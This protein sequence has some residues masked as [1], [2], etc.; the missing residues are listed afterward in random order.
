MKIL[1]EISFLGTAYRGYQVQPNVPTVQGYLNAATKDLFGFDCDIVG[2]SR[3]DSG[4]HSNQFFLTV[5]K[6]GEAGIRT[7]IPIK[8]IPLALSVRLPNDISVISARYVDDSFHARYS[9]KYKEYLYVIWNSSVR[10]PF[11]YDRSWQYEK[12][13]D[14]NALSKMNLAAQRFVGTHDFSAYMASNTDVENTVRTIFAAEIYREGEKIF[15]KV[16]A[17]GFLYNMVRILTGTLIAVAEGKI[18]PEDIDAITNS[19]NR[20]N[21]GMTVP[22]QGLF[23]NKVVY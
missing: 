1:L 5:S 13:I 22:A 7:R 11:G 6:K 3:T 14:D 10:D 19:K 9:V 21:A 12:Y 15:F 23:L 20:K 8:K 4:V 17:D 2:C 16:S 18:L